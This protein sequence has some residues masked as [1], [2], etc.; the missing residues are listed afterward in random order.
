[1]GVNVGHVAGVHAIHGLEHFVPVAAH[2]PKR[3]VPFVLAPIV[4][5][6]AHHV[7][8]GEVF[9]R[10][11]GGFLLPAVCL[12]HF[13]GWPDT[14]KAP[15]ALNLDRLDL[16]VDGQRLFNGRALPAAGPEAIGPTDHNEAAA[17]I[18]CVGADDL[19]LLFRDG[20]GHATG[21]NVAG[22]DVAGRDV[23]QDDAVVTAQESGELR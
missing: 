21:G 22:R 8:G 4:I 2:I 16:T 17:L 15:L 5:D 11:F 18:L 14:D 23:R 13:R 20:G 3:N 7:G 19:L 1:G 12:R 10:Q 6:H 9:D